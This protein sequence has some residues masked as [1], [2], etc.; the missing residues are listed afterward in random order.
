MATTSP[1]VLLHVVTHN[2]KFSVTLFCDIGEL[3]DPLVSFMSC[4]VSRELLRTSG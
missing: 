2:R 4:A 1:G 3:L